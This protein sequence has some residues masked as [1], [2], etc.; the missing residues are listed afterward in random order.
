M[1]ELMY[2]LQEGM[3]GEWGMLVWSREGSRDILSMYTNA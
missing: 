2:L 1:K 3:L